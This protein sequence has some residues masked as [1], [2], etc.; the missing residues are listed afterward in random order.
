LDG[1]SDPNTSLV[2]N[3]LVALMGRIEEVIFNEGPNERFMRFKLGKHFF[4]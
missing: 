3:E 4:C 2:D 1:I